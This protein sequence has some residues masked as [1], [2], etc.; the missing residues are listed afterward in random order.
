M[1]IKLWCIFI[2]LFLFIL[3][4]YSIHAQIIIN[5]FMPN[6]ESGNEWVE[7]YNNSNTQIDLS[8]YAIDDILNGGEK[9]ISLKGSIAPNSYLKIDLGNRY[10]NNDSDEINL[11]KKEECHYITNFKYSSTIKGYSYARCPDITGDFV[12]LGSDSATPGDLNN[13]ASI[14]PNLSL[15]P[16]PTPIVICPPTPTPT[17]TPIPTSTPTPFPFSYAT[18]TPTLT[19]IKSNF[20]LEITEIYPNPYTGESEWVEIYNPNDFEVELINWEIDDQEGGSSPIS[21]STK[22]PA[23]E[24][25]VLDLTKTMLNNSGD[26]VRLL[27][28][29]G[30]IV[31]KISYNASQKDFSYAKDE[32]GNWC[33]Q[34]PTKGEK[35][36]ICKE[37]ESEILSETSSNQLTPTPI[38]PSP[39][40]STKQNFSSSFLPNPK[41]SNIVYNTF[42]SPPQNEP[43]VLGEQT[44]DIQIDSIENPLKQTNF[45]FLTFQL[46]LISLLFFAFKIIKLL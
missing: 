21:F 19:N 11:I 44:K 16:I 34:S 38:S 22:I 8:N 3:L 39:L 18:P 35:N 20:K 28:S 6:P 40:S 25:F 1:K 4:P 2:I 9:E 30:E 14:T 12:L 43:E 10:L 37:E 31:D 33:F 23:K 13:C 17:P 7:L 42:N 41:T 29:N 24:F 32:K 26:E 36:N 27:N 15:T 45:A 46:N 5:E